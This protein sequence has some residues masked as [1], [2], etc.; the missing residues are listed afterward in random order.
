MVK[1]VDMTD[2]TAIHNNSK[3]FRIEKSMVKCFNGGT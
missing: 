3:L 2:V 1:F